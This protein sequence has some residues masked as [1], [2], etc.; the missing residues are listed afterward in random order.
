MLGDPRL[1]CRR[2]SRN[3]GTWK[4]GMPEKP[5]ATVYYRLPDI[6]EMLAARNLETIR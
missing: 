5:V 1:R 6:S 4:S 3:D 2:A